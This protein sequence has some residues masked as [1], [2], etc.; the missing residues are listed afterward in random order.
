MT[1]VPAPGREWLLRLKPRG[2]VTTADGS[3][4]AARIAPREVRKS[5]S[6]VP[7]T[8][9][10][11]PPRFWRLAITLLMIG[12]TGFAVC[13]VAGLIALVALI[14]AGGE[15]VARLFGTVSGGAAAVGLLFLII[16]SEVLGSIRI[17]RDGRPKA[18]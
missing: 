3:I 4:R 14:F 7:R 2:P 18:A 13:V 1:G 5:P 8:I 6:L 17:F 9:P 11:P 10:P 12:G 15:K 16:G